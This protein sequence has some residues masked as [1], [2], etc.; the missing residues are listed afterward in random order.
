MAVP[1]KFI[2]APKQT[3]ELLLI[4]GAGGAEGFNIAIGAVALDTQPFNV[5]VAI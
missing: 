4:V 5:T 3:G 1:L 2:V